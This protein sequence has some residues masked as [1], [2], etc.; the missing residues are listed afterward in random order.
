[1][2]AIEHLNR[3]RRTLASSL[4]I[5]RG[6]IAADHLETEILAETLATWLGLAI[7]EE[8]DDASPLQ[9]DQD[10][11]VMMPFPVGPVVDFEHTR[12]T[13]PD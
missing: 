12:S 7:L 11:A 4:G 5:H 10:G 6:A 2:L 1:V 3:L 9:V 8:I 13:V